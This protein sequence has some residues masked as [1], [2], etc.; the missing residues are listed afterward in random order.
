MQQ[1][2]SCLL[3]YAVKKILDSPMTYISGNV[4]WQGTQ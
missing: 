4:Y 3:M 1:F 2:T